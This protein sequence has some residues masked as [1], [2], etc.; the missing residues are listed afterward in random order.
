MIRG[1]HGEVRRSLLVF[2]FVLVAPWLGHAESPPS[3][4]QRAIDPAASQRFELHRSVREKLARESDVSAIFGRPFAYENARVALEDAGIE[5]STDPTLL[6]DYGEVLEALDEHEKAIEVLQKAMRLAP[7]HPATDDASLTLAFAFAKQDRSE[8]ELEH[9]RAYLRSSRNVR[10]LSTAMLNMAEAE[11]RLGRL[12]EA[13]VGYRESYRLATEAQTASS[14]QETAALAC[15]GL[16]VALDRQGDTPGSRAE[17]ARA[18]SIDPSMML[19]LSSPNV[20]FVPA[21][22][23]SYYVGMGFEARARDAG[24]PLGPRHEFVRRSVAAYKAYVDKARPD[25]RWVHRAREHLAEV[26]AWGKTLPV[27]KAKDV[28]TR[29]PINF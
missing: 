16:A 4:W 26:T 8:E 22:E 5:T 10:G 21:Y 13:V 9:Y 24:A 25:D 20:F 29:E 2:S 14:S 18:L 19:V 6:F 17:I 1:Y 27:A 12:D 7:D 23:R 3:V 11:M 28:V 15:Y